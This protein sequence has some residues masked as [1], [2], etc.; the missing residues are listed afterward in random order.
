MTLDNQT[1]LVVLF[2]K[3]LAQSFSV[4][5]QNA[6]YQAAGVNMVY[7]A[8]EFE[9]DCLAPALSGLR[10]LNFAGCGVTKP[11]KVSI[12]PLLDQLD[13]LCA[14][15]GACNT[16]V[17]RDG[18]LTGYNT[19]AEGFYLSMTRDGGIP[20][21]GQRFFCFGAGGAGRAICA[22]LA[23]HGAERIYVTDALPQSAQALTDDFNQAF[24]PVFVPVPQG[25]F[26]PIASC[27][28]ILNASGV[29]MGSSIGKSPLPAGLVQPGQ[30][31]F[32]ACYNPDRT[33]FLLDAQAAG[34]QVLN[35]LNMLLYQ[36]AA[37]FRLWTG[38]EPPLDVMKE[39]LRQLIGV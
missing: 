13:P 15:I 36:A 4:A 24:G 38:L 34:A 3:P 30:L 8:E 28:A 18:V 20:V 25:D 12:M 6:A 27:H 37:Q 10:L 9:A 19:D 39:K 22:A 29:G 35:G 33:Q 5:L 17:N 23:H 7:L 1:K 2:G 31:C 21:Q 32:D 11:Y 14:K 16:V 26:S